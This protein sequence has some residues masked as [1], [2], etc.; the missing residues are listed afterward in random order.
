MKNYKFEARI[1]NEDNGDIVAQVSGLT[2]ES[3]LEET[4]KS[5]WINAIAKYEEV[6]VEE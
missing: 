5:S 3:M 6:I 1:I 2:E 4:G